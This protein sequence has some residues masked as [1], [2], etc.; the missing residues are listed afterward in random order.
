M[1]TKNIC[2]HNILT[3]MGLSGAEDQ[4]S[5]AWIERFFVKTSLHW[6]NQNKSRP[7]DTACPAEVVEL[8][9]DFHRKLASA[10]D[11]SVRLMCGSVNVKEDLEE[12]LDDERV[13]FSLSETP[14][15]G[16]P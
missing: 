4:I 7:Y 2:I 12:H 15:Y 13:Y 1:Y 16:Q 6:R 8:N 5:M 10:S 9:L 11:Y 3:K 14:S